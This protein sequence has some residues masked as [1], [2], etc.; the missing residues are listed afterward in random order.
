[1]SWEELA[2][3][4]LRGGRIT[5]TEPFPEAREPAAVLHVNCGEDSG[6]K[7][8]SAQSTALLRKGD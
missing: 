2:K 7:T 8:S 5:K 6:V 3:G 4:E 1:M